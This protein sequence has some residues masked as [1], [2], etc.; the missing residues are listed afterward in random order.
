MRSIIWSTK[1]TKDYAEVIDYLLMNWSLKEV[2]Y[3][4]DQVDYIVAI[5]KEGNVDFKTIR[6]KALHVAVISE[7][8]S[9]YYRILSKVK[10]EIVRIWHNPQNPSRLIK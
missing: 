7:H 2:Q 10:V 9:V 8:I 1:A 3:F 5:L 4:V 6:R